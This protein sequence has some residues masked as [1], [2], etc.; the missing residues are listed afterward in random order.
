MDIF[1]RQKSISVS[2]VSDDVI[3]SEC[4][5]RDHV[6]EIGAVLVVQVSTSEI[7]DAEGFIRRY[8]WSICPQVAPKVKGIAGLKIGPGIN[9]QVK[10]VVGGAAGCTHLSDAVVEA[11]KGAVQGLYRRKYRHLSPEGREQQIRKELDG[12]CYSFSHMDENPA[13]TGP[14]GRPGIELA[15]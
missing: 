9:R 15:K 1:S 6:H 11:I 8:P 2:V 4:W 13:Y 7:L 14:N 3:K 12:S 10:Q 5:I